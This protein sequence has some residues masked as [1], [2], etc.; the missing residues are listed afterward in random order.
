MSKGAVVIS[1]DFEL[2]WG[3]RDKQ[4]PA[5]YADELSQT[6]P[7]IKA[8]LEVFAKYH[9]SATW[10]VVGHLMLDSATAVGGRMHP[11]MPRPQT[12][13]AT[14]DWYDGVPEGNFHTEPFYYAP[15]VVDMIL[16]CPT[17]QELACHT[18]SHIEVGSPI[19]SEELAEAEFRRCKELAQKWGKDLVSVVFPRNCP[20]HLD[21][22][23]RLGYRCFRGRNSEWYWL[24]WPEQILVASTAGKLGYTFLSYLQVLLRLVDEKFAFTPPILPVRKNQGLWEIPHSMFFPGYTGPAKFTT[25]NDRV[26][27][28]LKGLKAAVQKKRIFSLWTHPHNLARGYDDLFPAFEKICKAIASARDR[29]ELDV[30]TMRE[31][32][33]LLDQNARTEWL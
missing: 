4:D 25:P 14:T 23:R 13:S 7:I 32:A 21:V 27:K 26:K 10:A 3:G 28:A 17:P 29:N 19:C 5:N 15:D 1:L 18:F 6:R 2:A 8:M 33:D 20:G 9:I 24:V 11:E 30:L 16:A 22:L 12:H 31:V